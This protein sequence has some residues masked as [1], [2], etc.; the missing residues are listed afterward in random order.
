M[1]MRF[2]RACVVS[3]F[4][5]EAKSFYRALRDF[6]N[7]T[8]VWPRAMAEQYSSGLQT[9]GFNLSN[10]IARLFFPLREVLDYAT[11]FRGQLTSF[12]L[13]GEGPSGIPNNLVEKERI[14]I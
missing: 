5:A 14:P 11:Q 6:A 12:T 9:R 2:M 1:A 8:N 10:G 3:V 7:V 13:A 4:P